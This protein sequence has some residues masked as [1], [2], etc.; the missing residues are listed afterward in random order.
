[1]WK[2]LTMYNFRT[3]HLVDNNLA[4]PLTKVPPPAACDQSM[5]STVQKLV[6][7]A[8]DSLSDERSTPPRGAATATP[9]AGLLHKDLRHT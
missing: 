1:M 3:R 8:D 2:C 9:Y 6:T 4:T 7:A 5:Q